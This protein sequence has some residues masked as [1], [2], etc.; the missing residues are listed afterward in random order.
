[1]ALTICMASAA[2]VL[3]DMAINVELA[4]TKARAHDTHPR[5]PRTRVFVFLV[6]VQLTPPSL[7]ALCHP[8]RPTWSWRPRQERWQ[9]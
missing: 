2:C 1:M 3:G 8:R 4:Y 7:R 6:E 5:P 9:A